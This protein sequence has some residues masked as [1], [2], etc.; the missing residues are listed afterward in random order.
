MTTAHIEEVAVSS[1]GRPLDPDGPHL[2][3]KEAAV[4]LRVSE[5]SV[6]RWAADGEFPGVVNFHGKW[7]FPQKVLIKYLADHQL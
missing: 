5:R 2:T 1:T 3:A 4:H 6:R 7:L